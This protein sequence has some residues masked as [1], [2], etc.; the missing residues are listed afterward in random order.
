MG[1]EEQ[2]KRKE[3]SLQRRG[4]RASF[5]PSFSLFLYDLSF[6]LVHTHVQQA[7]IRRG[8]DSRKTVAATV[9][10]V[11]FS[12]LRQIPLQEAILQSLTHVL[13]FPLIFFFGG[14]PRSLVQRKTEG[15]DG[16]E[17]E[18]SPRRPYFLPDFGCDVTFSSFPLENEE[19]LESG[20][21]AK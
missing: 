2:G 3:A 1:G 13:S 5:C 9:K 16:K 18:P 11:S 21:D 12:V 4:R 6:F 7:D 20:G 19:R 17:E 10:H 15:G 14:R 8:G